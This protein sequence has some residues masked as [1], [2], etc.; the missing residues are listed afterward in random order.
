MKTDRIR[1]NAT[2]YAPR[3]AGGFLPNNLL[4]AELNRVFSDGSEVVYVPHHI[5]LNREPLFVIAVLIPVF[6]LC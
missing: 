5:P 1:N 3:L 2:I 4:V 6:V